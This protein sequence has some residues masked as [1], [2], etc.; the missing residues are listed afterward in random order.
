MFSDEVW[1]EIRAV[2]EEYLGHYPEDSAKRSAYAAYCCICQRHAESDKQFK[3]VG[4][5]LTPSLLIHMDLMKIFQKSAADM[6]KF[7]PKPKP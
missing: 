2:Y 3:L 5:R 7:A 6:A 4:D 1:D